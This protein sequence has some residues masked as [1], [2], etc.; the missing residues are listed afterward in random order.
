MLLDDAAASRLREV[1]PPG[2]STH[3][4]REG[5]RC[6]M[7]LS[8]PMKSWCDTAYPLQPLAWPDARALPREGGRWREI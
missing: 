8:L 6:G 2:L 7:G 3:K 5:E 4:L 1:L